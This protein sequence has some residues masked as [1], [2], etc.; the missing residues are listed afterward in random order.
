MDEI[1]ELYYKFGVR[2]IDFT[3]DLFVL[4]K[5]R[6]KEFYEALK[7]T[8]LL[9]KISFD[10]FAR[11][12]AFDEEMCVLLKKINVGGITF[13][14]ESGSDRILK[15]I[16]NSSQISVED[17]K[18]V[19]ILCKKYGFNIFGGLVTANPTETIE[20][21][22]KNL[23]F[24]DFARANGATRVWAQ[25]LVPFPATKM[26]EIAVARGKINKKNI[27]WNSMQV[28]NKENLMLLDDNISKKE[29]LRYY[30][31]AK[32][33]ARFFVYKLFI[34][35][36]KNNPVNLLYFIKDGAYYLGRLF[37]FVKQ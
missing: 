11:A 25:V 10:C 31:L 2:H 32:K 24:M 17:N 4:N 14:F 1:K 15:Y 28:H 19:I 13:G 35:T 29:F 33:K 8:G 22:K 5:A 26:W 30:N 27:D 36:V 21:M 16:K 18:K 37:R 3:D 23:E 34:K 12:D 6:L 20:D 7:R 9:N